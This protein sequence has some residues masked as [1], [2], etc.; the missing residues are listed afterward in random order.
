MHRPLKPLGLILLA[1]VV[2]GTTSTLAQLLLWWLNAVPLPDVLYRDTRFAAAIVLPPS[3]IA[4]EQLFKPPTWQ[5]LLVATGIHFALSLLYAAIFAFL[6]QHLRLKP[7]WLM[8]AGL[9]FGFALYFTNMYGFTFVMPW[10]TL[11]R[12]WITIAAH[13]VFGLS[14]ALVVWANTRRIAPLLPI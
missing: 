6:I 10:F 12:D 14:L 13:A 11:V 4:F 8:L 1:G 3:T 5:M 9:A 2:A 7:F